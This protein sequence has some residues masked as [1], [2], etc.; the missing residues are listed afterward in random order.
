ML[1]H[2]IESAVKVPEP[3]RR[4]IDLLVCTRQSFV[5]VNVISPDR[6]AES[7]DT[8]AAHYAVKVTNRIVQKYKGTLTTESQ[9]GFFA[10]KI[11]F[12]APSRKG[13]PFGSNGDDRRQRRKQGG[14]V[15][16]SG[17]QDASEA[18]RMLGAATRSWRVS[19]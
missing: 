5:V 2:A 3:E 18:W 10:V 4:C 7:A 12:R 19:A 1:D 13:S 14:A 15:G 17:Q 9:N 16:G 8:R 6:P 11:F